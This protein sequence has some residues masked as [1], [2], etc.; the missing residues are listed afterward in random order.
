MPLEH[1][2]AEPSWQR[3]E[4]RPLSESLSQRSDFSLTRQTEAQDDYEKERSHASKKEDPNVLS[5]LSGVSRSVSWGRNTAPRRYNSLR[6]DNDTCSPSPTMARHP[7]LRTKN[8][9][10]Q[11]TSSLSLT[12]TNSSHH[13]DDEASSVHSH[14]SSP[15]SSAALSLRSLSS[16]DVER[17]N[18]RIPSN[19]SDPPRDPPGVDIY[20]ATAMDNTPTHSPRPD[21]LGPASPSVSPK[22]CIDKEV[23][24]FDEGMVNMAV[25][26]VRVDSAQSPIRN[27]TV[28]PTNHTW[29]SISNV[30]HTKPIKAPFPLRPLPA[31]PR[32]VT[33]SDT[34]IDGPSRRHRGSFYARMQSSNPD[35]FQTLRSPPDDEYGGT[36]TPP[37]DARSKAKLLRFFSRIFNDQS[38][39]GSTSESTSPSSLSSPPLSS[40]M[41][42]SSI[43]SS[44]DDRRGS[45]ALGRA[46][47]TPFLL[48]ESL[49]QVLPRPPRSPRIAPVSLSESDLSD[50]DVTEIH[51]LTTRSATP[52]RSLSPAPSVT[53]ASTTDAAMSVLSLSDSIQEPFNLHSIE[54]YILEEEIGSG[55]YGFVRRARSKDTGDNVVI[56]YIYKSSIFADSWRRHR[57]Y[58]TI[59]G[60]IFILLQLQHTPYS[61][62]ALP[63]PYICNKA[64]WMQEREKLVA[65]QQSG[66]V[67]GHPG[68]CKLADFFEDEEYYY[69]VMPRFGNGHDLFDYVESSMFGIEPHEIR[70]YLGQVA[71]VIAFLHAN[72]LVHRD[73]KD[74]NVI[75]DNHGMIQ[76][77]DF[78]GAT[79]LRPGK[80]FDTFSGTMDYAAVEILKGEKYS[81]PPQ[82]VWAFGIV[83]YVLTCGECPFSDIQEASQ[84][85]SPGSRPFLTL[86]HFCFDTDTNRMTHENAT[87]DAGPEKESPKDGGGQLHQLF[88]L[89]CQCLQIDPMLR[90][91][92]Q[93]ILRHAFL[94]GARGWM[95]VSGWRS[96]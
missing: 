31:L 35:I 10:S 58:G 30:D 29:Q 26:E 55:A 52:A 90:P 88:D 50:E 57:V 71:D 27:N 3:L 1:Y 77:I 32:S 86:H 48:A 24:N 49:T 73:I 41:P 59:P 36:A 93:D 12:P 15:S 9:S 79:R 28:A 70:N 16:M 17:S 68:I 74:E 39:R 72:G 81:G 63:P 21:L 84:G 66:Q 8:F 14:T 64:Y 2:G 7:S 80:L 13:G 45:S 75:L 69:M 51:G 42:F 25:P 47:D 40:S 96:I 5:K 4:K 89:I 60:E 82:D 34:S 33:E 92:A 38:S 61:P 67:T 78:G 11:S 76:V 56:K 18:K 46:R 65:Q 83:A 95:G 87:S 6:R 44:T 53:H 23:D 20:E 19:L 62:P 54:S 37:T 22:S 94:H 85:L 91:S 43:M